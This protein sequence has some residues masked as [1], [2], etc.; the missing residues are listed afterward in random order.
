MAGFQTIEALEDLQ[1]YHYQMLG[2]PL[3][4][5]L[6][7]E[8]WNILCDEVAK[9]MTDNGKAIFCDYLKQHPPQSEFENP[10]FYIGLLRAYYNLVETGVLEKMA[11]TFKYTKDLHALLIG[12]IPGGC[13]TATVAFLKDATEPIVLFDSS[14]WNV[15]SWVSLFHAEL[16]CKD[17]G[18]LGYLDGK[19]ILNNE[20]TS[21][22]ALALS[23]QIVNAVLYGSFSSMADYK[24]MSN[25]HQ[26]AVRSFNWTIDSFVFTHEISHLLLGHLDRTTE[27]TGIPGIS[28]TEQSQEEEFAADYLAFIMTLNANDIALANDSINNPLMRNKK[29]H[30]NIIAS[31]ICFI[32]FFLWFYQSLEVTI[33]RF[34]FGP[35]NYFLNSATH[36]SA[37]VRRITFAR[38]AFHYF[39]AESKMQKSLIKS[40]ESFVLSRMDEHAFAWSIVTNIAWNKLEKNIADGASISTLWSN[41]TPCEGPSDLQPKEVSA[42]N[43]LKKAQPSPNNRNRRKWWSKLWKS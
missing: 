37:T 32:E 5:R 10:I 26:K 8:Q 40:L 19:R 12:S 16:V 6:T 28:I 29:A 24:S 15:A 9:R 25:F 7:E 13:P 35:E 22:V 27:P 31:V 11:T 18:R 4:S 1:A 33:G 3:P 21:T 41:L 36:P 20:T 42:T 38:R 2:I 30:V 39:L 14:L 17:R 23:D 43:I 34:K